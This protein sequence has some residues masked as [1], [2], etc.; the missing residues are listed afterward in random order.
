MDLESWW[1]DWPDETHPKLNKSRFLKRGIDFDEVVYTIGPCAARHICA[2]LVDA[3]VEWKEM[4]ETLK[5]VQTQAMQIWLQADYKDLGWPE[6]MDWTKFETP[7]SA[8]YIGPQNGNEEFGHLLKWEN[9]PQ[10]NKPLSIWY[11]CG[12]M[13]NYEKTPS[14]SDTDYPVRQRARV[15]A[16]CIQYLQASIGP[17]L[18]KATSLHALKYGD[19]VGFNFGLLWNNEDTRNAMES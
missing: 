9:W 17:M 1:N 13:P 10:D 5:G 14:F 3:R 18:P 6:S 2:E 16:Q 19:A 7:C 8:T 15:K 11:F 4:V 12:L